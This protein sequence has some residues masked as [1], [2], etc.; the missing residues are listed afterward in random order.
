VAF[1]V[2]PEL[3]DSYEAVNDVACDSLRRRRSAQIVKDPKTAAALSP[4]AI[5]GGQAHLRRYQQYETFNAKRRTVVKSQARAARPDRGD[6]GT[7][8]ARHYELD[9]LVFATG[10]DAITGALFAMDIR[11][12]NDLPC[13]EAEGRIHAPISAS[14]WLIFRTCISSP[15]PGSPSVTA[16]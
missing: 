9:A 16:T 10:F 3:A 14:P 1:A 15:A 4:A 11:G 6:G 5:R 13:A 7:T 12:R 2:V 8:S